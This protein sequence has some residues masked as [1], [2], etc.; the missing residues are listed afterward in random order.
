MS[1]VP[2]SQKKPPIPVP[3]TVQVEMIYLYLGQV[4]ENV[5]HVRTNAGGAQPTESQMD[6]LATAFESWE[7]LTG[8]GLRSNQCKLTLIRIRDLSVIGGL[9]KE[10]VPTTAVTGSSA[11]TVCPGN[12]T[13][14]VRWSTGRGGRS[15]RGRTYLIGMVDT[16]TNGNQITTAAQI[17]L[18]NAYNTLAAS[19]TNIAGHNLTVV[20]YA[21]NKFWRATGLSTPITN[22]SVDINLDSQRRRLT[23]RGK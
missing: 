4:M 21:A 22:A 6:V 10:Y 1:S 23:G 11:A 17:Q 13:V 19:I 14:A 9:V 7:H 2:T 15:F 8:I 12:V 5:F 16:W 20:S 18:A 3:A